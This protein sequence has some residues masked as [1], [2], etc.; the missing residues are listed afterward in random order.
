MRSPQLPTN[1]TFRCAFFLHFYQPDKP[2]L[3]SYGTFNCPPVEDMPK[4]LAQLVP[5]IPVD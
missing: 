3:T 5:F 2:L 1:D 4:R